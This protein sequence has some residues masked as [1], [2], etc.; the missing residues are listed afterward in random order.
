MLRRHGHQV[1]IVEAEHALQL[2]QSGELDADLVITNLP[3]VFQ[4]V[5][6]QIRLVYIAAAPDATLA[7]QFPQC[8]VLRKPF[9]NEDLL[10]AVDHLIGA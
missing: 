8:S 9:R 3:L 10:D 6:A 4:P 2:L 7:E 1:V 5:A